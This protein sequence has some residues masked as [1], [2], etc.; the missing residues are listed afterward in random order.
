MLHSLADA[1][2]ISAAPPY[3]PESFDKILLD[4]PC[5]AL[6]Q[7]PSLLNKMTY[8]ELSSYSN[9]QKKLINAAVKLLKPGGLMVYSTCTFNP[10]ENELQMEWLLHQFPDMKLESQVIMTLCCAM[11][12]KHRYIISML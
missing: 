12:V 8:K 1:V 7:R 11:I 6:G 3:P 9:L 2:D 4:A 10:D 5:S